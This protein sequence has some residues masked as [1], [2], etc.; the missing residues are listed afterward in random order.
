[1]RTIKP[2][3]TKTANSF[4]KDLVKH[5]VRYLGLLENVR[6]RRAGFAFRQ[7]L[8]KWIDRY[9]VLCPEL[10]PNPPK[11]MTNKR[12]VEV[13]MKHMGVKEDE[14]RVGKT[15]VFIRKPQTLFK[16]EEAR[17]AKFPWVA[18]KIQAQLRRFI[19]QIRYR[20]MLAA[21][22]IIQRYKRY[23]FH[24]YI[25]D[26]V[27]A[28][29]DVKK[30][31]DFG[32]KIKWPKPPAILSTFEKHG[33]RMQRCWR[34]RKLL[35]K[36]TPEDQLMIKRKII[37]MGLFGHGKVIRKPWTIQRKFENNYFI[38]LPDTDPIKIAYINFE[39][40]I[41]SV[42]KDPCKTILFAAPCTKIS[43]DGK[44]AKR[45]LIITDRRIFVVYEK[46]FKLTKPGRS[47]QD[48]L[49]I[50]VSNKKD[51]VLIFG[52]NGNGDIFVDLGEKYAEV[53][54]IAWDAF[55][56]ATSGKLGV[57]IAESVE[58]KSIKGEMKVTFQQ[59]EKAK[60]NDAS[61]V[62][63]GGAIVVGYA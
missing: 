56:K 35:E 23:K 1:M 43:R 58:F 25:R 24:K 2:N 40:K 60:G 13:L 6:V 61:F 48:I 28:F 59:S 49:K 15:K 53:A 46:S 34:M 9:K 22:K 38:Q 29:K 26:V 16:H 32:K 47:H 12:A 42:A 55:N 27:T 8:S 45:V 62:V 4:D 17:E 37:A 20:K 57:T 30:D 50:S 33:Q 52:T 31:P 14:F 54:S 36:M 39:K 3:G 44:P 5:Q 11:S 21:F 41:T 51:G 10:W 7:D 18:I 19:C 63:R